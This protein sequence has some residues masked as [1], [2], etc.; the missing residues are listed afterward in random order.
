VVKR[1]TIVLLI[2]KYFPYGGLQRDFLE[3]AKELLNRN[4]KVKVLA[5]SWQGEKPSNLHIKELH[6]K[7]LTNHGKNID[8]YKKA[9]VE[10]EKIK[11][12]LVFGFNKMPGLHVY[13]AADTC[14]KHFSK[15]KNR[16]SRF[17][18]R[19]KAFIDYESAVFRKESKTKSLVL[20]K[21]QKQEFC[22]EYETNESRL[23][24]IPPG[25]SSKWRKKIKRNNFRKNLK[26]KEKSTLMLFVGS[27]FYRKGL[28][29]AIRC[30]AHL[31]ESRKQEIY[32]II[33]GEDE[34]SPFLKLAN[35]LGLQ[36]KVIFLGPRED[37]QE[38]MYSCD[39]LIHPAREE[40][41]GNVI[42][43]S[44]ISELPILTSEEVGFSSYVD[45][46]NA[47]NVVPEPFD[48]NHL[49]NLAQSMVSNSQLESYK[50]NLKE[51][52]NDDFFFSRFHF[53]GDFI[54]KE[55]YE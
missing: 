9:K 21:K 50:S 29:R 14:F 24:L 42:I 48:Q 10:L 5:G 30:L 45:K 36:D 55:L 7:G 18:P 16:L 40:A 20:N 39:L 13:L 3:V 17:L 25:L 4:L 35:K 44:M 6:N 53:I 8:F 52:R 19:Y 46:Y 43:E 41:A 11:P 26:L 2:F 54:E 37:I 15:R 34:K 27:S 33:A 22:N 38:I 47:G 32:L 51:L 23:V 49:D 1:K 12:D 31:E 28:D